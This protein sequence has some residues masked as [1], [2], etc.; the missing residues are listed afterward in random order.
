M[1][2]AFWHHW[3]CNGNYMDLDQ[4]PLVLFDL[5]LAQKF[6]F[7]TAKE[8]GQDPSSCLEMG[9]NY[10]TLNFLPLTPISYTGYV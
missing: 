9:L 6:Y 7:V 10:M 2:R 1:N 3:F 8:L 5:Y 4:L